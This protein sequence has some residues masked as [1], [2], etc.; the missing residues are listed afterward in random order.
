MI[1]PF[2]LQMPAGVLTSLSPMVAQLNALDILI[3]TGTPTLHL[4]CSRSYSLGTG[5]SLQSLPDSI[6]EISTLRVLEVTLLSHASLF[7][8]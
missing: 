2:L 3:L 6:G 8:A 1:V 5:N 7:V 4:L